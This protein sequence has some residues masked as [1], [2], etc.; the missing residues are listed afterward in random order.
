VRKK[1]SRACSGDSTIGS[2]SLKLV[3][4]TTGVPVFSANVERSCVEDGSFQWSPV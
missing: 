3:F 4:S 2:F 1:Q